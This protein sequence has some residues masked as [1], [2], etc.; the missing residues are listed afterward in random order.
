MPNEMIVPIDSLYEYVNSPLWGEYAMHIKSTLVNYTCK[1]CN[2]KKAVKH[3]KKA[4]SLMPLE[5]TIDVKVDTER[6]A[7]DEQAD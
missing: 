4:A 5:F 7:N 1:K 2:Y 3:L 6:R